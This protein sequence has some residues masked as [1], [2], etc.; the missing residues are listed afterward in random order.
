MKPFKTVDSSD[1][2]FFESVMPGRVLAVMICA[3][4]LPP[5]AGRI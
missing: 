4:M 5:K 1:L 3:M 2:A